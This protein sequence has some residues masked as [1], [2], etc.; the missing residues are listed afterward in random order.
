MANGDNPQYFLACRCGAEE[1]KRC[2]S[3]TTTR[4]GFKGDPIGVIHDGRPR[5]DWAPPLRPGRHLDE[6][7]EAYRLG[8]WKRRALVGDLVEDIAAELRMTRVALDRY[9]V[10]ARR[11][12]H[13]DAVYHVGLRRI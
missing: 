11:R 8:T 2:V 1:G 7:V 3:L 6:E 12:G 10:R 9:V 4:Y 5:A 13:P